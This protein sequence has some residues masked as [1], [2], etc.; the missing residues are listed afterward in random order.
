MLKEMQ[1]NAA[2]MDPTRAAAHLVGAQA[3]AM[4]TA[5]GNQGAGPAMAFMGMNMAG[6]AGGMNAQNLYQMGAQQ[7]AAAQPA[8]APASAP[9]AGPAAAAR[10]AT[11]ANSAQTAAAP[12]LPRHPQPPAGYAAAA[13]PTPVSSAAT[14]A[15]PSPPRLPPSAASAAGPRMTRLIR[16]SSARSAVSHLASDAQKNRCGAL[17]RSRFSDNVRL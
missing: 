12:S 3:S 7:Q 14:A 13:L 2:F 11:P 1:R 5:A 9:Q 15:A 16:P 6:A 8:P 10:P 4:Q 17:R